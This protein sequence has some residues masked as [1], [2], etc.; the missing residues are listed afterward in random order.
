MSDHH[1]APLRAAY[2]TQMQR[3]YRVSS[4][5]IPTPEQR[6]AWE[7]DADALIAAHD[8]ETAARAWDE[9]QEAGTINV[10]EHRP[11]RRMTNPYRD[12]EAD[13]G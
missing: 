5:G 1:L 11:G 13:R 6:R 12:E 8:R 3:A 9:G 7:A 4:H 2:V 10:H